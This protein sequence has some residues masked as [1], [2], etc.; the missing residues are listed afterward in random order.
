[1]N[2]T[3][4]ELIKELEHCEKLIKMH[5]DKFRPLKVNYKGQVRRVASTQ[6]RLPE[7]TETALFPKMQG[8]IVTSNK[9]AKPPLD[10]SNAF[11]IAANLALA[12]GNELTRAE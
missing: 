10:A 5:E 6:S 2:K 1:M 4:E 9:G 11:K 8:H 3:T 12:H 7:P